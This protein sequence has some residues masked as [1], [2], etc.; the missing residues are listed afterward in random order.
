MPARRAVHF[1]T[2]QI[3]SPNTFPSIGMMMREQ[4]THCWKQNSPEYQNSLFRSESMTQFIAILVAAELPDGFPNLV[5]FSIAMSSCPGSAHF[6]FNLGIPFY[7]ANLG[8]MM[9]RFPP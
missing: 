9:I 1:L 3:I 7:S 4:V 5:I 6:F 2:N 8:G